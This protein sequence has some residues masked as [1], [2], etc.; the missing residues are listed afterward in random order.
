MERSQTAKDLRLVTFAR[1]RP[2]RALARGSAREKTLAGS[3]SKRDPRSLASRFGISE[4][5]LEHRV[6]AKRIKLRPLRERHRGEVSSRNC[7]LQVVAAAQ[8]LPDITKEPALLKDRFGIVEN[9]Q[10]REQ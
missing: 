4:Q 7:P 3:L 10:R 2:H 8:V 9:L 5:R 6:I 1:Q